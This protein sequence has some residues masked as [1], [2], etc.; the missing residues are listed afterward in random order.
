L[1]EP[2][3]ITKDLIYYIS[4]LPCK[5][6]DP[7]DISGGKSSDLA[8]TEAMKKKYKLVKKKMGYTISNIN[9]KAVKVAT[10]ILVG[11]VM[12]KCR[13]NEVPALVVALA[14]QCTEGV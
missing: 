6:E 1:E 12:C 10:Q 11:K 14:E 9:A 13:A 4:Q 5:G 7:A 2:I 3:P 8:I